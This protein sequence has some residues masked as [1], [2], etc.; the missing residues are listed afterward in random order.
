MNR[1]CGEPAVAI[2]VGFNKPVPMCLEH[3]K[4]ALVIASAMGAQLYL[5]PNVQDQ[6][7]TTQVKVEETKCSQ[8]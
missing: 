6:T 8:D 5:D 3:A 2:V 4:K 1:E 7:C